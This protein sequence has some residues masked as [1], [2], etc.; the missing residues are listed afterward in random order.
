[1]HSAMW[2][3]HVAQKLFSIRRSGKK[4]MSRTGGRVRVREQ[5]RQWRAAWSGKYKAG[6]PL[7]WYVGMNSG[8]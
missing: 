1:M 4:A 8:P 7:R 5:G 6:V 2:E 3:S